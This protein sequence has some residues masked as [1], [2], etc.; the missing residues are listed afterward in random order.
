[1]RRSCA[2]RTSAQLSWPTL[3]ACRILRVALTLVM[4]MQRIRAER[5][6]PSRER[7]T[8]RGNARRR[9]AVFDPLHDGGERVERVE[10]GGPAAAMTHPRR[11]E[12]AAPVA[13][14]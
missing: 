9:H 10:R 3:E 13:H 4:R 1:M 14:L 11:Q 8:G 12:Q 5:A 6:A 2:V 7:A